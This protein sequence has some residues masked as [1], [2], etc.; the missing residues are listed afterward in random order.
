MSRR[1]GQH[2]PFDF[3]QPVRELIQLCVKP[4]AQEAEVARRAGE[5]NTKID[6]ARKL[7]ASKR[8]LEM[9]EQEQLDKI[10]HLEA[11]I[12]QKK[13]LIAICGERFESWPTPQ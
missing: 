13:Q 2:N 9:T 4:D 7:L 5:F 6:D 12:E 3:I 8:G 1:A 11:A 10:R